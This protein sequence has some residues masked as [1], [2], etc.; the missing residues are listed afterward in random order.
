MPNPADYKNQ[1]LFMDDC[2]H[3]VKTVEGEPQDT[4]VAKCL[5]MWR[6]KGKKK[7]SAADIVRG[8]AKQ[9]LV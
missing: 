1:N 4:S 9:L 7:E 3:Q 2:M 5:G 6:G 8:L